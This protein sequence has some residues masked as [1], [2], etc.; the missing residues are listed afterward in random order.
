MGEGLQ[1]PLFIPSTI[2]RWSDN[3]KQLLNLPVSGLF[4]QKLASVDG[5]EGTC[6]EFWPADGKSCD[7]SEGALAPAA[8]G[9]WLILPL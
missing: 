8:E 2:S 7:G 6:R 5:A 4:S 1:S 3:K 9:A